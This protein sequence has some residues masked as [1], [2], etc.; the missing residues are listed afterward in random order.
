MNSTNLHYRNDS[1]FYRV[2]FLFEKAKIKDF[3]N[4]T[5]HKWYKTSEKLTL[6][7]FK[8]LNN[9]AYRDLDG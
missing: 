5:G 2:L 7:V 9:K 3:Y 1:L 8:I 6:L 4:Q